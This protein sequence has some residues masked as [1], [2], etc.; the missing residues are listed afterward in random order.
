MRFIKYISTRK[1][2][3]FPHLIVLNEKVTEQLPSRIS[4]CG[5]F[6]LFTTKVKSQ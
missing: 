5:L 3:G 2:N 4:L 1:K 6:L